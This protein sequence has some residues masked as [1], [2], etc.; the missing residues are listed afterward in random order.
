MAEWSVNG[1][2][3][4]CE[5]EKSH[6]TSNFSFSHS[7]FKRLVLQTSE[8]QGLFVKGLIQYA[9]TPLQAI[10]ESL[11]KY[12]RKIVKRR[13]KSTGNPDEKLFPSLQPFPWIPVVSCLSH[14]TPK[15]LEILGLFWDCSLKWTTLLNFK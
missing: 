4:L 8:N 15:N 2:K 10:Q 12:L 7:V 1:L 5:K 3:T 13:R 11:Q 6:V 9:V 14:F